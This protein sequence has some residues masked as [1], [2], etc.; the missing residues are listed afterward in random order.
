MY[1]RR[2][3]LLNLLSRCGGEI[4]KLK[5]QKLLLIFCSQQKK[6][7]YHFV[8]Y[9]YGCFSFQANA[10]LCAMYKTGLVKASETTWS[11]K[12]DCSLKETILPEDA[13][14]LE[15][16]C[17]SYAKMD[18]PELIKHTYVAYPFYALNSTIVRQLLNK[19]QQAAV[20]KAIKRDES[21]GLFTIGY[22]GKSL[23]GFLNTLLRAN[24]KTLCDV[25]KNA[26]SM[27]YGFSKTTLSNACENVGIKYLHMPAVGIDSSE[28]KGLKTPAD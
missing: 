1:Y 21:A 22:E 15:R 8:P 18:T 19:G 12:N 14:R 10:D 6:P 2:K 4:E 5:L 23:E 7:A 20:A 26:Y 13:G 17:S 28:R 9:K 3:I 27:K 25:R 11:L 24:I 16:V